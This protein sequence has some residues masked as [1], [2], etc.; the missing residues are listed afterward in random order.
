M[1]PAKSCTTDVVAHWT[2]KELLEAAIPPRNWLSDLEITLRKRWLTGAHIAS[3]QHPTIPNLYLP[4]WVGNFWYSLIDAAK[5]KKKWKKAECWVLGQ[6][7]DSKVYE[8]RG[9][10]R[11]I[12]W[13][14]RIWA[15]TGA[16][17]SSFVGVLAK[18]LST[19]WLRERHLDTFSSYLNFCARED[20]KG[21]A[22][23]WVGDVYL[24][25]CLKRVYREVQTSIHADWDLNKYRDEI[26]THGYKRLLFPANLDNNHWIT[27][28]VDLERKE[29]RYG[30]PSY[31]TALRCTYSLPLYPI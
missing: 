16:E 6:V 28:G 2:V 9:L 13:G 24:S 23:W 5:Q 11:Q 10:M 14:M 26:T 21:R 20:G 27:F 7:Q 15:L 31:F 19:N 30:A 25:T 18:L 22:A 8:A 3:I 17:S 1:R 4:L 29:F 12:P